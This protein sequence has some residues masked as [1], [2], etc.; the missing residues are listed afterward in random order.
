MAPW[1]LGRTP[2]IF[3]VEGFRHAGKTYT[4]FGPWPSFVRLPIL[5]ISDEP[6]GHMTP[7]FMTIAFATTLA[8]VG[9]LQWRLREM[10]RPGRP[11]GRGEHVLTGAIV[12]FSGC[13]TSL[14]FLASRAWV[15]HEACSGASGSR[16]SRTSG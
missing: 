16:S 11:F 6:S 5:A 3:Y 7:L 1:P 12:F 14:L 4:Y 9:A 8:G 2:D 15:Y 10:F 13:G